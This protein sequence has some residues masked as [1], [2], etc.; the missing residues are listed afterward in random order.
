MMRDKRTKYKRT[1]EVTKL[2]LIAHLLPHTH[3]QTNH[4]AHLHLPCTVTT[5]YSTP[6]DSTVL[7]VL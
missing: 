1:P 2:T 6:T 5:E 7:A 4:T 3:V